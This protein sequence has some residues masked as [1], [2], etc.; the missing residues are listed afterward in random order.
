LKPIKANEQ[1]KID[2]IDGPYS[3]NIALKKLISNRGI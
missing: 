3:E 1:L 2:H